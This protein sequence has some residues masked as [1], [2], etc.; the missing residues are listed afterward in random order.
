M[1]RTSTKCEVCQKVAQ[2]FQQHVSVSALSDTA[3]RSTSSSDCP[4]G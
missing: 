1:F 2:A 4:N 3:G